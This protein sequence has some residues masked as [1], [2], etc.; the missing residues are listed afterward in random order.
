MNYYKDNMKAIE[1]YRPF[2]KQRMEE[3]AAEDTQGKYPCE[4]VYDT[5]AK[6][7]NR[8]LHVVVEGKDYRLNSPYRPVEEARRWTEQYNYKDLHI[9]V[10]LFGMG[11]F[12]FA[13]MM[14][15]QLRE[16]ATIAIYE[17]SVSIWQWVLEHVDLTKALSDKRVY[18][19]I[20]DFNGEDLLSYM[21]SHC[22]WTSVGSQITCHHTGYDKIFETSYHEVLKIV[23]RQM[24]LAV[25]NRDTAAYFSHH[26]VQNSIRNLFYIA[27]SNLIMEYIEAF[28]KDLPFIIV[29]AGP[30]LDKNI[31]LLKE[32]KNHSF[33]LA[34]DTSIKYLLQHEI[35]P[36]AMV[37]IDPKKP[38]SYISDDRV[39]NVPLFC[40]Q[41]SNNTILQFHTGKK[42]WFKGGGFLGNVLERQDKVFPPYNVGG[43]VATAAFM[44]AIS[45][46]AEHVIL[47]GQDLA[48]AGDVTH[49][50]GDVRKI[51]SE[52][53]GVKTIEGIHGEKVKSRYD[54]LIYLSWFEESIKEIEKSDI[55]MEVI[56]ATEGGALIRGTKIMTLRE[57]LDQYCDFDSYIDV[58][59]VLN[60]EKPTFSQR[61]YEGILQY[62]DECYEGMMEMQQMAK[63]AAELCKKTLA[64]LKKPQKDT[65]KFERKKQNYIDRIMN[66]NSAIEKQPIYKLIDTYISDVASER[67]RGIF[68]ISDDKAKDELD[69]ITNTKTI[70]E[71][72][73]QAVVDLSKEYEATLQLMKQQT[74]MD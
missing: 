4:E 35:I 41:E 15:E 10:V 2:L 59:D 43:S 24:N 5:E 6:D 11:N 74:I 66:Y 48:Y 21:Q 51:R 69:L 73:D 55:N 68:K 70:Y 32:A 39:K 26:Y 71:A 56:D 45:F 53:H 31:D 57:A 34:T 58:T 1:E 49:A 29:S 44:I 52:K 7:G 54:W 47:I 17:P 60:R 8:V 14:L 64:L 38:A 3:W 30:S 13:G 40:S 37:T 19:I 27:N 50:G 65:K 72:V 20:E 18:F 63:D 22:H 28:S 46:K 23:Q 67:L 33:I 62:L 42:I 9:S 36:D 25:V 12:L 61:E 16:D